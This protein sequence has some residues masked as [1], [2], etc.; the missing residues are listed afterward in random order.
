MPQPIDM[1]SRR[2]TA[3]AILTGLRAAGVRHLR[4]AFCTFSS[5]IL[6]KAIALDSP[7]LDAAPE[8]LFD[9][10]G[11]VTCIQGFPNYALTIASDTNLT[12]TGCDALRPD[13]GTLTIL[14]YM[15]SHAVV[16]GFLTNYDT[17]ETPTALCP[18]AF[19]AEQV[20]AAA[21]EGFYMSCG[22]EFEFFLLG[23]CDEGNEARIGRGTPCLAPLE[24]TSRVPKNYCFAQN[25]GMSGRTGAFLD[26]LA[27]E[28]KQQPNSCCPVE[29]SHREGGT[30]QYEVVMRY[31]PD[32]MKAADTVL[33]L[34]ETLHAVGDKHGIAVSLLPKLTEATLGSGMH[35]HFSVQTERGGMNCF[36]SGDPT[37]NHGISAL[38]E[39]VMAGVLNR[40]DALVAVTQ[41]S[42]NSYRRMKKGCWSGATKAWNVDDKE[43]SLRVC[44]PVGQ[45][46]QH[47]EMKTS[48][49]TMNPH[50]A[51]G[52]I[53]QCAREG[54]RGK[55][56]LPPR[57]SEAEEGTVEDLPSNFGDAI[58]A[59]KKHFV[60]GAG[61]GTSGR[62]H[63]VYRAV[64]EEE[65]VHAARHLT[66]EAE[67]EKFL[68]FY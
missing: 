42:S 17:A 2:A 36:P 49:A 13:F 63:E 16:Y 38:G 56:R 4:V 52:C 68:T 18:R 41:A 29:L 20:A 64:K 48:D 67:V 26:E 35:L 37:A 65:C 58:M 51:L 14:P 57:L 44:C 33:T 10:V 1:A 9:G 24:A 27:A 23:E 31:T 55:M 40:L 6:S 3:T 5:R 19:L 21:A 8:A 43:A 11:F 22:M 12:P 30:S 34:R 28:L 50:Y 7:G 32:L 39:A 60:D 54:V 47:F 25:R 62:L 45:S 61:R 53:V 15:P 66:L 46:P 59:F